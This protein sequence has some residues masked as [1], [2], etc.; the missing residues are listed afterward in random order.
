MTG[1]GS[2]GAVSPRPLPQSAHFLGGGGVGGRTG[3]SPPDL[4]GEGWGGVGNT[5]WTAPFFCCSPN[6]PKGGAQVPERSPAPHDP[7]LQIP[8][9]PGLSP[10][11]VLLPV[12]VS[13]CL[14]FLVPLQG[15]CLSVILPPRDSRSGEM[16]ATQSPP[17]PS[18]APGFPFLHSKPGGHV[19]LVKRHP[20]PEIVQDTRCWL[21][22]TQPGALRGYMGA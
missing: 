13:Q 10:A 19:G 1:P 8:Y 17:D 14:L 21:W 20:T 3:L 22:G 18:F 5:I 12:A 11:R 9:P 7:S 4:P 16:G 6:T 2:C 15:L